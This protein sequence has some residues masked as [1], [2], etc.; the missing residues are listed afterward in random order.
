MRHTNVSPHEP[1][2]AYSLMS[3]ADPVSEAY[4]V[5]TVSGDHAPDDEECRPTILGPHSQAWPPTVTGRLRWYA[6]R[7]R[8]NQRTSVL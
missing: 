6:L 4:P 8:I 5:Y 3:G 2:V 7:D 1:Q